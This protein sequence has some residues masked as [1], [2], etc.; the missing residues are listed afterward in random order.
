M[1]IWYSPYGLLLDPYSNTLS[2]GQAYLPIP[3]SLAGLE[4]YSIPVT[5]LRA[6]NQLASDST[7]GLIIYSDT[8]LPTNLTHEIGHYL[9]LFHTFQGGCF[10]LYG[11]YCSDTPR[12]TRND[13]CQSGS[14]T[15]GFPPGMIENFMD[16]TYNCHSLFTKDQKDRM[17]VALLA[18]RRPDIQPLRYLNNNEWFAL[19]TYEPNNSASIAREVFNA[20]SGSTIDTT[21][22]S[23]IFH[24]GDVDWF[25]ISLQEEGTLT[26]SLTELSKNYDLE[27]FELD[28][29]PNWYSGSYNSS[30]TSEQIVFNKQNNS[31]RTIGIKVSNS[32]QEYDRC[33]PYS[34][35]IQWQSNSDC[36]SLNATASASSASSYSTNDGTASIHIT[37]GASPYQILWSNGSVDTSL[38][39]LTTGVYQVVVTDSNGCSA[40]DLVYVGV[41][42]LSTPSCF[43]TQTL[44][45]NSGNFTDGSDTSNYQNNSFCSWHVNPSSNNSSIIFSI[46]QLDLALGDTLFIYNGSSTNSLPVASLVSGSITSSVSTASEAYILFKSNDT[47]TSRGWDISYQARALSSGPGINLYEY[48]F[49]D[50]Q[51]SRIRTYTSPKQNLLIDRNINTSQLSAGVHTVHFR[52][53]YLDQ[54]WSSV[55]SE[56]F[57]KRPVQTDENKR[58]TRFEYWFD[59]DAQNRKTLYRSLN[60]SWTINDIP[61]ESLTLGVHVLHARSQDN[62][63]RWSS[64]ISQHF[65]KNQIDH[66]STNLM[67]M[68]RYWFNNDTIT[69]KS[70][71]LSPPSTILNLSTTLDLSSLPIGSNVLHLQSKD[72][73]G[74]WS[75]I[76]SDTINK[77]P[78]PVA[79]FSFTNPDCTSK[80][81]IF[82]NLSTESTDYVWQFGDGQSDTAT[83]P[84][85]IYALP[86]RYTVTL[87]SLYQPYGVDS[88]ISKVITVGANTFDTL[89]VSSC[90][91][92]TSPISLL[93]YTS[94]GFYSD[95][96]SNQYQ[97]DSIV[98]TDLTI[99]Q[100]KSYNDTAI[101]CGPYTSPTGLVYSISGDYSDTLSSLNT[102]DSVVY[103]HLT[104]NNAANTSQTVNACV[105]Y[106]SPSNKIYTSSGTYSDTLTANSGCD[107]IIQTNL[108]IY[109]RSYSSLTVSSC[110]SFISPMGNVYVSSGNYSDTLTNSAG[111]DSVISINLTISPSAFVSLNDTACERYVSPTGNVYLQSGLYVDTIAR[112]S[113]CDSI[114]ETNLVI[115][116]KS[117]GQIQVT[118]CNQYISPLGR[119]L[120]SSGNYVD[121]LHNANGCDSILNI[122]LTIEKIDTSVTQ[123]G[124]TLLA[125]QSGA[126]YQWL[127]CNNGMTPIIG[128]VNQL[129]KPTNN[130]SYAV[131]ITRGTCIDTSSCHVISAIGLHEGVT[132]GPDRVFPNP[133]K[134]DFT[135]EMR[136]PISGV[137][138]TVYDASGK[139]ISTNQHPNGQIF[140]VIIN[141]PIGAYMIK[142]ESSETLRIF[143]V[144]K[145]D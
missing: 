90:D 45:S 9:G 39:N 33:S 37:G 1:N 3:S 120:T 126:S 64:V 67:T 41:Q 108:T 59:D 143:Q 125:N 114:I 40:S 98:T 104:I 26:V 70:V 2:L 106:T 29:S 112:T 138:I 53:Q 144:V 80:S 111:C 93:T 115:L 107:S 132:L 72:S 89:T 79:D 24:A 57:I 5:L 103:T 92:F 58:I 71:Q 18:P 135:I 94:S 65:I 142:V 52:F 60:Q 38:S 17:H 127:D 15:F 22:S 69:I 86:G 8:V 11:D 102:C 85:H 4:P 82:T 46:N 95:T 28:G 99:H 129:F 32:N 124:T 96:L 51:I 100:T 118:S 47:I 117:T 27:L 19:D 55:Y 44:T 61:T 110:D 56:Y 141:A 35:R 20:G 10:S 14:C 30:A 68:Y 36:S 131:S 139:L 145:K 16:Y 83:S 48:W 105:S 91:S 109:S 88:L 76:L 12:T 78:N 66:A 84:T 128:E 134:G 63:G 140:N 136:S 97:C 49:D 6:T 25:E 73:T 31:H 121:T 87:R 75:S 137:V 23:R 101:S 54:T 50:N 7:D 13:T 77:L 123:A 116:P 34:L 130:G 81:V 113:G 42:G 119:V 74:K 62:S 122:S 43:G 21:L 133:S